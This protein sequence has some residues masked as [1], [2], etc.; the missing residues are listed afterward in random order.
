MLFTLTSAYHI[1]MRRCTVYIRDTITTLTFDVKAKCVRFWHCLGPTRTFCLLWRC[2][3]CNIFDRWVYHHEAQFVAY[4]HDPDTTLTFDLNVK[5]IE[6][7]SW[8]C[9]GHIFLFFDIVIS[10]IYIHCNAWLKRIRRLKWYVTITVT[11]NHF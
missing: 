11:P 5:L 7:F 6:F 3:T 4:I 2:D 10:Y 8:L 9:S 1:T